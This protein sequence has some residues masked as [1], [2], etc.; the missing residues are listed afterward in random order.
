M[1]DRTSFI[2]AVLTN[3]TFCKDRV[4][5]PLKYLPPTGEHCT[6][7]LAHLPCVNVNRSKVRSDAPVGGHTV[8]GKF[9]FS[10]SPFPT[11]TPLH[12]QCPGNSPART[13]PA[14]R[15]ETRMSFKD[16]QSANPHTSAC[17]IIL[18]C[19]ICHWQCLVCVISLVLGLT[20]TLSL[21]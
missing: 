17:V 21:E 10:L 4:L 15:Q 3:R 8:A 7:Y 11:L 1:Y 20:A 18:L 5:D 13:H 2:E 12:P 6:E 14:P 9:P 16:A 19:L